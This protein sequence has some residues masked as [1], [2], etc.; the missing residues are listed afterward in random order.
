VSERTTSAA[1]GEIYYSRE[2]G[3]A[4]VTLNR[5]KALNALTQPMALA[6][7][8][9]LKDWRTDDSVQAV[10]IRGAAREDGRVPFCSGGDIRFLHQQQNDPERKFAVTF[11]EQEYR[12]NTLVFRFPKPYVALIDG[13]VMGGG[14]G[15]SFHGSHRVMSE[16]ALFAMPETGIGLFPDVGAT[17]FLPRCPGR[18]GL[19][20]GLSGA[21]IGVADALYLG[22][23]TH[24]V[25]SARMAQFDAALGE[26]GADID[27]VLEAFSA[28]PGE[29]PL[30][31]QQEVV[32]RCFAG[33]SV[34]EI[35]DNLAAEGSEWADQARATLLEKSPTSLKITHRQLTQYGDLDFEAAMEIEY[36]MAI[37]CNFSHEFYEGIRAQIIDKD[38]QPKW[39]P[40]RLEDVDEALIDSYFQA[41]ATGDM[42]FE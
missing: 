26:A 19:Y 1:D 23:A 10:A 15:V 20:M 12:L 14:V 13:V 8:A 33:A 41:P 31:A 22:L 30:A 42:T 36:R 17:Y 2:G 5:P 25:P 38:R 4:R 3:L 32:D 29:A 34:E 6:L 9:W 37:R 11:Y 21:R 7:D 27:G 16:N 35:L 28:D 24:H 40:A 39:R 18:M